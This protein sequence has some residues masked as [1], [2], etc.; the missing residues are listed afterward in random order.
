LIAHWRNLTTRQLADLG[1]QPTWAL[2]PIA[3][4]E[5]HGPHLPVG[6]DAL[7]L[8]GLLAG[9]NQIDTE[10]PLLV[11]P[12]IYYGKSVEH[13]AF[14]GTLTLSAR[15]LL[16][17]VDD[18]AASLSRH[19]FRRLIILNTHGGNAALLDGYLQ[20]LR[21][22]YNL[23]VYTVQIQA[24]IENETT[25]RLYGEHLPW[26]MH[27]CAVETSLLLHWYPELVQASEI[28]PE[29]PRGD[30]LARL[31]ALEGMAK[32]GWTT[33]DLSPQG[34]IGDPCLASAA[35][36]RAIAESMCTRLGQIL[37]EIQS[38]SA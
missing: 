34:V 13:A 8:H 27:A 19:G 18:L 33:E 23:E 6:T 28:P 32:W 10:A 25:R 17:M 11:L 4:T 12:P 36:G 24:L 7:I 37:T 22:E 9:L 3:S 16:S 26:Q 31:G 1:Q 30:E 21:C 15:T 29:Q 38:R 5:Q 35:D 2:L 14:P 20:D